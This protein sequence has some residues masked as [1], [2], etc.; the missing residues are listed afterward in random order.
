[1][2]KPFEDGAVLKHISEKLVSCAYALYT[3]N[4]EQTEM[5]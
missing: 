5:N 1:M 3:A 2:M 4:A